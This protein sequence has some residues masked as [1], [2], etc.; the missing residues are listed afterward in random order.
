MLEEMPPFP[1]RESSLLAKLKKKKA[2]AAGV[3]S[4]EVEES[5]P[6][7]NGQASPNA[8]AVPVSVPEPA[9]ANLI[10]M[11]ATQQN[12]QPAVPNN[13]AG[14]LVDVF[15]TS[16]ATVHSSAPTVLSPG[17]EDNLKK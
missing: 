6:T 13:A 4:E 10:G 12:S 11:N 14:L 8:V 7:V 3:K 9:P 5:K 16:T 2:L 15:E 17:A 1:E